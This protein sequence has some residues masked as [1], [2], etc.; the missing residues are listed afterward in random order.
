MKL[1]RLAVAAAAITTASLAFTAC[2]PPSQNNT[3]DK[4]GDRQG[5]SSITI[6]ETNK[7][8]S[9]NPNESKSNIEINSKIAGATR[10]GFYTITPDLEIRH[11]D[12]VGTFEKISDSPLTVKYTVNE[13]IKWSDGNPMDAGDLLLSWA[14]G[15][16]YFDDATLDENG[17]V[18]SGTSYFRLA[19]S[20]D[21]LGLT[22]K[23]EISDDGR[24]ITLVY[25]KPYVDWEIAYDLPGVPAHVVAKRAGLA[26]EQALVDLIMNT[27]K[28]DPAAPKESPELKKVAN[29]WNED[30]VTNSLPAEE[31]LY[32]SSGHFIVSEI[33]PDQSLTMVR[34]EEYGGTPAKLDSVTVRYT[35]DPSA[36]VTALRNGEADIAAPQAST[37]TLMQLEGLADQGI[38]VQKGLQLSFDHVDLTFA[39][40]NVGPFTD[41]N[42][43]EAFLLTLPRKDIVSKVVGDLRKDAVPLDSQLFAEGYPH[44]D[45]TI[46]MN[47]S[48]N[49]AEANIAKATELLAGATPEVKIMY[50]KD[51]PN[52]LNS[53]ALIKVNAEQAG[54]KIVDGGEPASEWGKKLSTGDHNVS[55]FG[56]ISPGVGNV[57]VPQIYKTGGGGNYTKYSNPEI[58][59]LADELLVSLDKN[60]NVEI[61]QQIDKHL[62]ED[63]YGLPLFQSEGVV[64]YRDNIQGMDK[65]N[66]TATGVWWNINEISVK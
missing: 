15:S 21:G 66:P 11:N 19:G 55:I 6:A 29:V 4:S 60:R 46:A 20:T 39:G 10:A 12:D 3:G 37:D 33:Q 8:S 52:R 36:A 43:R 35:A 44:Y 65:Y 42:V 30:F 27:E 53:F 38:A 23:P 34:N 49:Y 18:T 45:A 1:T 64:G 61:K 47:T 17:T 57:V 24:S 31:E 16:G 14:Y 28:G 40:P 13:S 9:F 5:G 59:K 54:F 2:A 62:F 41:K 25:D 48:S 56:W 58:D 32:L 26:N 51:N 22:A 63:A 7:F 50:N